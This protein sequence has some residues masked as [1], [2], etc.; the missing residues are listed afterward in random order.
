MFTGLPQTPSLVF[1]LHL[2]SAAK[3]S[4]HPGPNCSIFKRRAKSEDGER[5]DPPRGS[6]H[7]CESGGL[8]ELIPPA[9]HVTV[10]SL[11]PALKSAYPRP[12]ALSRSMGDEGEGFTVASIH[13]LLCVIFSRGGVRRE[14]KASSHTRASGPEGLEFWPSPLPSGSAAPVGGL[15]L[16][17][18][19]EISLSPVICSLPAEAQSHLLWESSPGLTHRESVSLGGMHT[20]PYLHHTRHLTELD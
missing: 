9:S 13:S 18:G 1:P 2:L 3:S 10:T 11:P 14:G 15:H 19:K 5:G 7:C 4:S 17:Q 16:G 12:S 6:R 20:C 8:G